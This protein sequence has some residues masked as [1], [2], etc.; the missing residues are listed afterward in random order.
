MKKRISARIEV[1]NGC[2]RTSVFISPKNY[3]SLKS[4]KDLEKDWFVECKF[5]DPEFQEKYPNGF[6]FRRRPEK[7][8]TL[9]EQKEIMKHYVQIMERELDVNNFNPISKTYMADNSKVLSPTTDFKSAVEIARLKLIGSDKHL[10]EVRIAISRFLKSVDAL[11]YSYINV[12]EVKIWHIKNC[13]DHCGLSDSYYNKFRQYLKDV[14][15]E[16]VERGCIDH[17]PVR[18]ISKRKTVSKIREL[19]S[20]EKLKYI[21]KFLMREHYNFYRYKEIFYRSA[22]RSSELF[23]LQKKHVFLDKQEYIIQIQ[24]G[25]VYKWVVKPI[26]IDALKYWKEILDLCKSDEDFLFS[27][28]LEPGKTPISSRQITIRWNTHVKNGTNIRDCKNQIITVTE[29]FYAFKY[30]YLDKLDALQQNSKNIS[31]DFNLAQTAA[32]HTSVST[33]N[34]YTIGHK[35]RENEILKNIKI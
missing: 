12:E 30:M 17:N 15:K 11:N 28:N 20:D 2:S 13:L 18:D 34:I 32:A 31:F 25:K 29:D 19:I 6:Q 8:S 7:Q 22:S 16:L 21:D 3:K 5:Y 14:F 27:K 10:N 23:R 33:T 4:K 24:K 1:R 35:K 9:S 26:N